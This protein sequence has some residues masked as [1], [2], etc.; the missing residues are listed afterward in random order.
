MHKLEWWSGS[1]LVS[2]GKSIICSPSVHEES[3]GLRGV[4]Q[5]GKALCKRDCKPAGEL[6]LKDLEQG[7]IT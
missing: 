1:L 2:S 7:Q 6:T 5:K 4:S 3:P